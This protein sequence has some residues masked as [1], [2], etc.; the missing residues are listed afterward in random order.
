MKITV[1]P[2]DS[3][4]FRSLGK[5]LPVPPGVDVTEWAT[6]TMRN[7]YPEV[8]EV[9]TKIIAQE[10]A[11]E[12]KYVH[13]EIHHCSPQAF[14]AFEGSLAI[15]V[16]REKDG[17]KL[18]FVRCDPTAAI[19]VNQ[20]VWHGGPIAPGGPARFLV[21]LAQGTGAADTTKEPLEPPFLAEV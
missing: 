6:Q 3:P 17:N 20:G 15:P 12:K 19:F 14:V 7:L 1:Q 18:L 10:P 16:A 4:E 21:V 8:R 5:S 9:E 2:G 13:L 11:A